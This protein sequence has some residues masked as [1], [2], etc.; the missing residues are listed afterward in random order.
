MQKRRC[1]GVPRQRPVG[2]KSAQRSRSGC[3]GST[4]RTQNC[5]TTG[6]YSPCTST[7]PLGQE[8]SASSGGVDEIFAS[9]F[10]RKPSFTVSAAT[11][12]ASDGDVAN[13][14]A[15]ALVK[16]ADTKTRF[17]TPMPLDPNRKKAGSIESP[18]L[19]LP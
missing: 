12:P 4:W 7:M 8:G 18:F 2:A 11:S 19:Q 16:S 14:I 13:A 5:S 15:P 1:T 9:S 6:Q 17:I 3:L 10:E